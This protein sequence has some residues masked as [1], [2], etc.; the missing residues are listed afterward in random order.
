MSEPVVPIPVES[1]SDLPS[2]LRV[3]DAAGN[4]AREGLRVLEDHARFVLDDAHLTARLKELRH[5]LAQLFAALPGD[6]AVRHRD[7][8]RDV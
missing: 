8:P 5:R 6:G 4:R 3:L 7:T 1:A 2:V